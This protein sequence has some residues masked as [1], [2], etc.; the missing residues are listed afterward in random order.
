M[1]VLKTIKFNSLVG[2]DLLPQIP[3][4]H[5][6]IHRFVDMVGANFAAAGE[7]ENYVVSA[8]GTSASLK[9][10]VNMTIPYSPTIRFQSDT[11]ISIR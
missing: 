4:Q 11:Y 5:P 7:A 9:N 6:I 1:N 3:V 8:G 10:V 2:T